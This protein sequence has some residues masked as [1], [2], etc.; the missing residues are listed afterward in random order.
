MNDDNDR[1]ESD[2]GEPT[3]LTESD[4]DDMYNMG[5]D[6]MSEEDVKTYLSQGKIEDMYDGAERDMNAEREREINHDTNLREV[7]E[8]Y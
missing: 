5:L 2:F 4:Y 1:I 8:G 6:P 3:G 7:A